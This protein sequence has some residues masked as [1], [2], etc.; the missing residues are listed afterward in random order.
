M[1]QHSFERTT[2]WQSSLANRDNE[3]F[4]SQRD[5]LRTQFLTFRDR[6]AMLVSRI[7]AQ[8]PNLTLHDISHLD[9]LWETA[10]LI[11]GSDYPLNPLEGFI[12]GGAILLH[13][14]AT[15]FEAFEG[16]AAEV[17]ATTAWKDSFA[18]E[19]ACNDGQSESDLRA[20]AD[21]SALRQLHA[22]Q[23]EKL[24]QREWKHPDTGNSIFLIDDHHLRQHLG[25]LIGKIANSHHWDIERVG[26]ELRDQVNSPGEFPR[27]W[28]IDPIKIA[29]LLRC[30]DALHINNERAPDFLYALLKRRGI[31][32]KHWH[33]QNLLSHADLDSSD[34]TGITVLITSTHPFPEESSDSWWIAFDA[35]CLADKEIR[36]SNALLESRKVVQTSPPFQIRRIKGT[37]AP[38]RMAEH[39]ETEGWNPCPVNIHVSNV[40]KLVTELGGKQ[41]YGE[42]VDFLEI[43]LR[44]LIQNARDSVRARQAMEP[45]NYTGT[46]FVR[47]HQDNQ[48]IYLTVEDDGLGMSLRVLTGPFLDFGSSFWASSLVRSEFPGLLSS[49]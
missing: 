8:L 49:G 32:F 30:A 26:A 7:A 45:N 22:E 36:S 38:E 9:A 42:Q 34:Q 23:A 6:V 27:E 3:E 28:K 44:E 11:A 37:E 13:D 39:I 25:P 5:R 21:F 2:L 24:P 16:G 41:L 4:S 18:A 15:C 20:T 17:R 35:V 40:E 33:A 19:C 43:A 14:A 12:L 10:S 1:V 31:S 46:V 47:L 48:N 29:C